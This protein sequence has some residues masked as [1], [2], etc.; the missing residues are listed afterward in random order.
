MRYYEIRCLITR[1][2]G[3]PGS[4]GS[5]QLAQAVA[6][7]LQS[8]TFPNRS[9]MADLYPKIARLNNTTTQNV[10]RNIARAAEACWEYGDRKELERVAGRRLLEKPTP[11][12][13]LFYLYHY[14]GKNRERISQAKLSPR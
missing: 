13:L 8:P 2:S 1:I 12:E 14:L 6:L 10:A 9:L 5:R 3:R 4:I 7:L 11:G